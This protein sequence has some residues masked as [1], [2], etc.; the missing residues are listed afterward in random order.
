M[1][2]VGYLSEAR[3]RRQIR[4]GDAGRVLASVSLR[5]GCQ[6]PLLVVCRDCG[7]PDK[8]ACRNHRESKCRP[9]AQMYRRLLG[10]IAESGTARQEG[11]LYLLTVTAP[12]ERAHRDATLPGAPPCPCTPV[13][14]VDLGV[15]NR[16]H[17]ARWNHLRTALRRE[18]PDLEFMRGVEVQKRGAL[19]DHAL[20][21]SP[22]PL[23]QGVVKR[24]A[25]RAGFGHSTD[26]EPVMPGSRKAA[27][28]ISKYVTKACDQRESVPWV[29]EYVDRRTGEIKRGR[30]DARYRTWSASRGWGLRMRD[31][32]ALCGDYA[33]VAAARLRA[34]QLQMLADTLGAVELV[35]EPDP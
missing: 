7:R 22:R 23:R 32:R 26:L 2:V 25:M 15:W 12:G 24:L 3:V 31:V 33:R 11:F 29:G 35:T 5:S 20:V 1:R 28:Y 16:S 18:Y 14:G 4:D 30:I 6:R 10:R 17:S 13:G 8:W 9:C 34:E 27:Y 21:W 19:H